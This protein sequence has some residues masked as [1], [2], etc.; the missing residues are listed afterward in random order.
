MSDGP[1]PR[2]PIKVVIMVVVYWVVGNVLQSVFGGLLERG[3]L[4]SADTAFFTG[5]ILGWGLLFLISL[6]FRE[7]LDHWLR[8]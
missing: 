4:V 1:P 5:L 8:S 6:Y 2:R 7:Q 3:G